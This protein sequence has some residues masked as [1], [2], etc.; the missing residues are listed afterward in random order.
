MLKFAVAAAALLCVQAAAADLSPAKWVPDARQRAEQQEAKIWTPAPTSA[1]T[2]RGKRGMISAT[3][4]PIAVQAGL[5]T[6]RQ[7]GTAADAAATVA[8]TQVTTQLGSVVSYAG[9][10]TMLYY[11]AKTGKISSLDA[12]YNSYRGESDPRSIPA[13][14]ISLLTGAPPPSQPKD[15]GRQT[16]VPGFMAGLEAMH[17]RFGRL[18]FGDLF[19]PAIWYAD[20]G[21]TISPAL[22]YFFQVRQKC[23]SRTAEGQRFLHQAGNDLPHAGDIFRQPELAVTLR[24]VAKN[25]AQ[26]MYNGDWAKAFVAAIQRDGG[27]VAP[28]DLADYR[29]TWSEPT[30]T[31]VFGDEVYVGGLPNF[32]AYQLLTALNL[33]SA[34]RLDRR[35]AYWTDPQTFRDLS[36]I[37]EVV[38]GAPVLHPKTVELLHAEGIDTSPEGQRTEAYAKALAAL[39]PELY[40]AGPSSD[41]HHSNAVV[42]V[43]KDGD[44]AVMTHTINAVIWGDTGIVV[45]GIPIP[46]SAGFQQARL[47]QIE[48]GARV[49]NE[50][51]DTIVVN[52][53]HRPVLATASIGSALLPETLRTIVSVIGQHREL[54]A[55]AAAPPLLISVDPKSYALPFA[56]RPVIVPAGAYDAAFVEKLKSSGTNIVELP[57]A[58][59]AGVRGT[60]ALVAIDPKSGARTT[61]EVPGVMVFGGTE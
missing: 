13:S 48:P 17:A 32:S 12:G 27:K 14:D 33:A 58:A 52:S 61:P 20:N 40:G 26:F 43:D 9:I 34:L 7:G 3:V 22:W 35:G 21:V 11:D 53:K 24:A 36:R 60:L 55:V 8:L 10:M 15:V 57:A 2:L 1:Q 5:E 30:H 41:P 39:L 47:A 19:A 51:A 44:I 37:G 56:Q 50:I 46:D 23:L 45:G 31:S 16:L 59:V 25:G 6:M 54:S 49:P 29:P 18:P 42:V 4:S 38:A 28:Q